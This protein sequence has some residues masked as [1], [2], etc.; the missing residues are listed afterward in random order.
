MR[1]ILLACFASLGFAALPTNTVFEVHQAG[2]NTNSGCYVSGLG[3]TDRSQQNA[4]QIT[5]TD[6]VAATA[7]TIS[8]VAFPFTSAEVGNCLRITS[9]TGWTTGDFYVTAVTAGVATMDRNI[10]TAA[11]TGGN[12]KLGGALATLAQLNTDMCD[13]CIGWVKADA[14]YSVTANIT[15][16][17]SNSQGHQS[18]VNGYTTTRGDG[19]KPTIR[20]TTGGFTIFTV[21][22]YS[23]TIR[24]F[25]LDC[26]AQTNS[27]GLNYSSFS[28]A[29]NIDAKNCTLI[30]INLSQQFV[31][32]RFCSVTAN[33]T[34]AQSAFAFGNFNDMSCFVCVA[35][36]NTSNGFLMTNGGKCHYC[37][38]LSSIGTNTDGFVI[39]GGDGAA[40]E[41]VNFVSFGN[42]RYGVN[43][44]GAQ[45]LYSTPILIFNGLIVNNGTGGIRSSFS[46]P[47]NGT[48]LN[49]N[50]FFN[51]AT[52]YTNV[53]AGANDVVLT[54]DPFV[55][56]G[57]GNF[58]LNSTAGAGAAARGVGF[59]G[60]LTF[61]G[62]GFNSIGPLVPQSSTSQRNSAYV[63]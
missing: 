7:T 5:Y 48:T 11:S 24:N 20:A 2:A 44:S 28:A 39:G 46:I 9:G 32:C 33:S 52:N 12:G 40:I 25:V 13:S 37:M 8:S 53:T 45:G 56:S 61:G 4:A 30:G 15:F 50:A 49:Y 41:L 23:K 10:A 3:G 14:V 18:Q 58:A 35:Y 63:Q 54:G 21:S 62:T 27:N 17:Y 42:A 29:E 16:N 1:L 19:G 22:F 55:S 57:S 31:T 51:N 47:S 60:V 34:T 26:N 43:I 36:N 6:L 59:P 38:A